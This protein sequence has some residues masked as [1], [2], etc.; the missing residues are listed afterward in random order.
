MS[1]IGIL[2]LGK[3]GGPTVDTL[4]MCKALVNENHLYI[5]ISTKIENLE[6]YKK[7]QIGNPERVK[8]LT[9]NTY[10]SKI[11]FMI[12][13]LNIFRFIYISNKIKKEKCDFIYLPMLTYWGAFLSI[14][15]KREK[16]ITAIHD[17]ESH[18]GEKNFLFEK[19]TKIC[20]N[21]SS[22]L[23]VF[24]KKFISL[25][26][27]RY[28]FPIEKIFNL[29]LGGYS[30]YKKNL[31]LR[32]KYNSRFNKILFF[33]R[34]S[35]YKGLSILLE[36]VKKM[37]ECGSNI[38]LKVV[39]NGILSTE[40]KKLIAELGEG[41]ELI[42]RWIKDEE[43]ESFFDNIDFT[44]LPYIEATQSGVI[45]LSYAMCKAVLV[46]NVGALSEQVFEDT[47]LIV[48]PNNVDALIKGINDLYEHNSFIEKGKKG[49]YY[50]T[51]E[52]TWEKQAQ[53]LVEFMS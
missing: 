46:T 30:Y 37:R 41:V 48:E 47:G 19:L 16:I 49:N 45:M 42:N 51:Y 21:K 38:T 36:A 17:P 39:G 3:K 40:E 1:Y 52:W 7:L 11:G 23:V 50:S 10:E 14:F 25:V 31:N 12:K 26:S 9:V 18:I 13:S 2:Y 34:I 53:K 22:N 32:E 20:V 6:E 35:K 5:V 28:S 24:S 29:K 15:L 8:I 44:V 33:G 27:E 43:V 4:E